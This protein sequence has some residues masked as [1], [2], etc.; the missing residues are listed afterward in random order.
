[1]S[2]T[3]SN[4]AG[5]ASIT[6]SCESWGIHKAYDLKGQKPKVLNNDYRLIVPKT[7]TFE[8]HLLITIRDVNGWETKKNVLLT[9]IADM[10]SPVMQTQLPAR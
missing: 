9:Y 8:E 2:G 10:E 4:Y 6:L 5:L 3:A 7:A 1:V